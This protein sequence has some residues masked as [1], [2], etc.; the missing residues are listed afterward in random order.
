[1]QHIGISFSQKSFQIVMPAEGAPREVLYSKNISFSQPVNDFRLFSDSVLSDLKDGIAGFLAE[2][3]VSSAY[4]NIA[5]PYNQAYTCWVYIPAGAS[6]AVK[7]KQVEWTLSRQLAPDLSAYKISLLKEQPHTQTSAKLLV[8]ALQKNLIR[9]FISVAS[10]LNIELNSLLLDSLALESF[11]QTEENKNLSLQLV[12]VA[13]PLIENHFFENGEYTLTYLDN[14]ALDTRPLGEQVAE[15][16]NGKNKEFLQGREKNSDKPIKTIIYGDEELLRCLPDV[17]KKIN[18]PFGQ[19]A[20]TASDSNT[21][22][23]L[24]MEALGSI[25]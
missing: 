24:A 3:N 10:D 4:L 8:V 25:I 11:I 16:V 12:K 17:E 9:R 7:K 14:L 23:S 1:M 21:T 15:I 22:H 19:P 6:K 13:Y 20:L 18:G 5:I 2:Y